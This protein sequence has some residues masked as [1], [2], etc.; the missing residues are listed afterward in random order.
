MYFHWY[1]WN[2]EKRDEIKFYLLTPQDIFYSWNAIYYLSTQ[3]SFICINLNMI[4]WLLGDFWKI[5]E[6]FSSKELR[7]SSVWVINSGMIPAH[8]VQVQTKSMIRLF[9]SIGNEITE[10]TKGQL[11]SKWLFG[12]IDF[13]QKTNE[14]K[15]TWSTIVVK[16]NS[17]VRFFGGNRW[18][19]KPFRN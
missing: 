18:P 10:W 15:A 5:L 17:F 16:S 9:G 4:R 8:V 7:Y 14:N 19:P 12:V 13:L 2:R 11:I 6:F 3:L 1:S